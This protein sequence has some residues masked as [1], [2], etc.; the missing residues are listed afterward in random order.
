MT[1]I[2]CM[3]CKHWPRKACGNIWREKTKLV[4][5]CVCQGRVPV[6]LLWL[7]THIPSASPVSTLSANWSLQGFVW[8]IKTT[9][10]EM[11][12]FTAAICSFRLCHFVLLQKHCSM[13]SIYLFYTV[14]LVSCQVICT[15][16]SFDPQHFT[17]K[18]LNLPTLYLH[19]IRGLTLNNAP[20]EFTEGGRIP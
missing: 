6:V 14:Q 8:A 11:R 12:G 9:F 7:V 20:W 13:L 17:W 18:L 4:C 2:K 5:C 16:L 10:L 19:E 3:N 15:Q 1:C